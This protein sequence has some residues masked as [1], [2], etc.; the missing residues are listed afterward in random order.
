[1]SNF[2]KVVLDGSSSPSPFSLQPENSSICLE[3]SVLSGMTEQERNHTL[4]A[5]E[6]PHSLPEL[7]TADFI[8]VRKNTPVFYL[9]Y[10]KCEG[11]VSE[12]NLILI[13]MHGRMLTTD[14]GL[15][16]VG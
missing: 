12:Q 7:L 13:N 6:A 15:S 3:P 11:S 8:H 2:Q 4:L 5:T 14:P 10:C 16:P 9:N 1:M